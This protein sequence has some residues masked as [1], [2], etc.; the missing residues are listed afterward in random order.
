MID[1]IDEDV[2]YLLG[3]IFARG[4]FIEK[5]SLK[6]FEIELE[7]TSLFAYG[8]DSVYKHKTEIIVSLS[9]IRERI[10]ELLEVELRQR[11]TKNSIILFAHFTKATMGWRNLRMLTNNK[12]N[13]NEFIIPDYFFEND[14][15]IKEQFLKGFCD[16]AGF[17][18]KSNVDQSGY[19]RVYFQIPNP[20]WKLPIQICRLLQV[21]FNIPVQSIQWGHPNTR[22]PHK[23]EV[24][25]TVTSWAKEHQIRV[26][27]DDFT[28][29]FGFEY[30]QKILEEFAA[31]NIGKKRPKSHLCYPTKK[32]RGPKKPQH[33]CEKSTLL[34]EIIR[35][36]HFNGFRGICKRIGCIQHKS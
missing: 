25:S 27:A 29:G 6:S 32:T 5:D 30:K 19:H 11:E 7:N 14:L 34:P 22:E 36:K 24:K 31:Y 16:I 1:Y 18:R 12:S 33:P 26:Y 10:S 13:H 28:I 9:K 23:T 4:K 17:I 20:N 2:A 3:M 15:T 21:D 35:G 8:I